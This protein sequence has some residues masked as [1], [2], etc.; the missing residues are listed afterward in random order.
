ME[1]EG[2][3][4]CTQESA[5]GPML[6]SLLLPMIINFFTSFLQNFCVYLGNYKHGNGAKLLVY[7]DELAHFEKVALLGTFSSDSTSSLNLLTALQAAYLLL[8]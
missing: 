3:L 6:S 1:T 7:G 5:T 2:S 4:P 8:T